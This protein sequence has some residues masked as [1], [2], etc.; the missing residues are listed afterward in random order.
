MYDYSATRKPLILKEYGRNAQ[1]LVE[2]TGTMEDKAKRALHAQGMLR[3]MAILNAHNK[4]NAENI[5]KRW[6]DLFI[7]SKYSLDVDNAYP[8]PE[9]CI[10]NKKLQ[11]PLNQTAYQ[12]QKLW[13]QPSF[14]P[15]LLL[16]K[17]Y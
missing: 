17:G 1:K 8:M 14:G 2:A 10:L 9:R 5:Q 7:I 12:I 6:D 13:P 15:H 4:H 3:L 11:R 16:T